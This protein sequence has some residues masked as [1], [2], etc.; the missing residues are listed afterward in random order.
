[1]HQ[2][3]DN[4]AMA[5]GHQTGT[6]QDLEELSIEPD[7]TALFL[8]FDGT[9]VDIAETPDAIRVELRDRILLEVLSMQYCDAV[10]ILSGRN[11]KDIERYLPEFTGTVSAGH[12]AELR[13]AGRQF[14]SMAPDTG[15]LENIRNAVTEFASDNPPLLAEGK[16]FG[17]VLHY[18]HCPELEE[19]VLSF[20][21]NVIAKEDGDT[22]ELQP[23][24][25]ALE[26]KPRHIS[27]A[28]A[29]KQIMEFPEFSGRNILVAGDDT[30]DEVGFA[31]VLERGGTTVRVGDGPTLAQY[32][33]PSPETMKKWLWH[34]LGAAE[35]GDR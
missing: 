31:W 16:R 11:L 6:P 10:S 21:T 2:V 15:Q 28:S 34:Q 20:M 30:T 3:M 19:R 24:K 4:S 13:H 12:G 7:E 29:I 27:K 35:P 9:L 22:F 32:R 5:D 1:M 18:R 26:I 17:A 33:T 8:D 25:M 23:A 14:S